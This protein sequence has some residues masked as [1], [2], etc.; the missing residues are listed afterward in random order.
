MNRII[1][2]LLIVLAAFAAACGTTKQKPTG[3]DL[4]LYY[5]W[6]CDREKPKNDGIN[7]KER[8]EICSQFSK[9]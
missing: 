7:M 1:I 6:E 9:P 3:D 8:A 5:A 4:A 2:A